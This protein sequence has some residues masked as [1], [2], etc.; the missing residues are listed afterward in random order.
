ML[1]ANYALSRKLAH[2][3]VVASCSLGVPMT[4]LAQLVAPASPASAPALGDNMERAQRQADNV[5]RWIKVH[6][7][8]PKA[9]PAK[10]ADPPVPNP[11]PVAAKAPAR[12]TYAA[13]AAGNSTVTTPPTPIASVPQADASPQVVEAPPALTAAIAPS[14]IP[15]PPPAPTPATA[16]EP[17]IVL[18]ALSQAQP[19]LSKKIMESLNDDRVNVR[20]T[21]LPNGTV[22]GADI[23]NSTNRRLNRPTLDAVS[24]WRFKPI[25]ANHSVTVELAFKE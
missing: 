14:A 12:T 13:N 8:K 22:T 18:V 24:S 20:F 5:L 6:S 19:E 15:A 3:W 23:V 17:E 7:D 16:A 10:P 11:S 25:Q 4:S 2:L 21:V 1:S 9:N